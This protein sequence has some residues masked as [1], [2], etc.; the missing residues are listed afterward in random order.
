M[1]LTTTTEG[2]STTPSKLQQE[3][4]WVKVHHHRRGKKGN[5]RARPVPKTNVADAVYVPSTPTLSLEQVRA[6][7]ERIS[8]QWKASGAYRRLMELLSKHSMKVNVTKAIC[9]GIGTFDPEDGSW[10]QKRKAHVQLAAFLAIVEHLRG[11]GTNTKAESEEKKK[12]GEIRCYFQEPVFNAV[13]RA[14]VESLG[15]GGYQVVESPAGFDLVDDTA[16]AFGVHLYRDV[17]TR[18]IAEHVPAMF[19]GTAYEV[20]QE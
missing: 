14:F 20:W 18:I 3:N 19:V 13:D 16:L 17:Y 4:E 12:K 7:H 1:S 8:N 10:E 11:V 15:P 2:S 5:R 9:F 6:E